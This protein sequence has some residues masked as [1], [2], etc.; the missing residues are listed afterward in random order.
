MLGKKN[1]W[2]AMRGSNIVVSQGSLCYLPFYLGVQPPL[3][4][5]GWDGQ[6]PTQSLLCCSVIDSQ[7]PV[8]VLV[9]V[10]RRKIQAVRSVAAGAIIAH[11]QHEEDVL[12][13]QSASKREL[14]QCGQNT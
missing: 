11:G 8:Q 2:E 1:S 7:R 12:M 13:Q 10:D 3:P 14:L 6:K 9:S 5:H 4:S